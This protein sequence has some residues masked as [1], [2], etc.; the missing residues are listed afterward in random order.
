MHC[1]GKEQHLQSMM[2]KFKIALIDIVMLI[3]LLI[4][5]AELAVRSSEPDRARPER[6]QG[7]ADLSIPAYMHIPTCIK[8][9][10]KHS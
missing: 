4:I 9:Y 8:T 5:K 10:K 7:C 3:I 6:M 2:V 1:H